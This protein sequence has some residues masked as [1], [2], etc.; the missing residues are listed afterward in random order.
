VIEPPLQLVIVGDD[1][2]ADEL[3]LAALRP[4]RVNKSIIRLSDAGEKLPP[5]LAETIPHLPRPA[6]SFAV[7]CRDFACGLP[8]EDVADLRAALQT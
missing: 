7:V 4:Y 3:E 1:R 5:A 8:L 2:L 6:G